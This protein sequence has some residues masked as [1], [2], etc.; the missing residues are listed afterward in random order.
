MTALLHSC[1]ITYH[2]ILICFLL[3]YFKIIVLALPATGPPDLL[4]GVTPTQIVITWKVNDPLLKDLEYFLYSNCD[5][6]GNDL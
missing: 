4:F 2:Q 5:R 6:T 3:L 1:K